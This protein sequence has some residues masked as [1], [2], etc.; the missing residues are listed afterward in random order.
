M[1]V[2]LDACHGGRDIGEVENKP[3]EVE[4]TKKIINLCV[5][6]L[7]CYDVKI[8]TTGGSLEN[9]VKTANDFK[10]NYFVSIH[11]NSSKKG[12]FESYVKDNPPLLNEYNQ[13]II[14]DEVFNYLKQF[15]VVNAGTKMFD[16]YIVKITKM[17]SLLLELLSVN[18]YKDIDLLKDDVFLDGLCESIVKGIVSCLKL[19]FAPKITEK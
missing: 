1:I 2:C 15:K 5:N 6:K 9:R 10:T 19:K 13:K 14:H 16:F 12:S 7:S 8:I 17:P 4:I 11:L 18:N 3:L